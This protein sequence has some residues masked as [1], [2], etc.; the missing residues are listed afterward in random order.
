MDSKPDLA[1]FAYLWSKHSNKK[2]RMSDWV[3]NHNPIIC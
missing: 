2:Y 3:K 1:Q